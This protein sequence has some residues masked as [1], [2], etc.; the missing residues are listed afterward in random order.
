MAE[1]V[2]I[3]E[4]SNAQIP[5]QLFADDVPIDLSNVDKVKMVLVPNNGTGTATTYNTDDDPTVIEIT[6]ATTGQIG[7]TPQSGDLTKAESPFRLF[8]WVFSS[9]SS[10]YAVPDNEDLVIEVTDDYE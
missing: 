3:R 8:F 9:A 2:Y 6:S 1:T 4:G 10:K 7:Y 5:F